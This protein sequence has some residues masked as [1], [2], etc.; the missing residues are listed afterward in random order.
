LEQLGLKAFGWNNFVI[1]STSIQLLLAGFVLATLGVNV[2]LVY[3]GQ[4]LV[5]IFLLEY[6]NY[7]EQ[8]RLST[9]GRRKVFGRTRMAIRHFN[10]PIFTYR[11]FASQRPSFKSIQTVSNT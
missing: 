5:A 7:I 2:L 11:T 9:K 10:K 6:V 3:W 8:L 1:R 4:S